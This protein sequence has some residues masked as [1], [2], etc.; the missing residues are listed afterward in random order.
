MSRADIQPSYWQPDGATLPPGL[1][2]RR[3][4]ER[5]GELAATLLPPEQHAAM[6]A[7][8]Q[9]ANER[10]RLLGRL[11]YSQDPDAVIVTISQ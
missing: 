9:F 11:L 6:V 8:L 5:L 1:L 7:Y 4:N 2:F 3:R 10:A